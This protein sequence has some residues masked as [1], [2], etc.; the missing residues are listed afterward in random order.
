MNIYKSAGVIAGM[1]LGVIFLVIIF[2]FANNNKKAKTDYDE[3]QKAMRGEAYKAAF[4]TLLAFEMLMVILSAGNFSLP[5]ESYLTHTLGIFL[6]CTVLG[7]CFI[8]KD[9]YWGMNNDR[10]RYLIIAGA[11][12][13][14][15]I[16]P[17]I[18][19]LIAGEMIVDGKLTDVFLNLMVLVMLAAMGITGLIRTNL[20]KNAGED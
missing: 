8:W 4:F 9:A 15:N 17:V 7:C 18:R 10:K 20:D 3:R 12:A 2:R 13:V 6:S 1:L 5:M 19:T 11:L 14:L 16:I